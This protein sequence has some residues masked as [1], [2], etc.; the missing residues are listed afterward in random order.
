MSVLLE[1]AERF[2]SKTS[3]LENGCVVWTAYKTEEGYGLFSFNGET[4]RAHRM[5]WYLSYRS[6]PVHTL[7]HTCLNT[8]CVNVR[9]MQDI[10]LKRDLELM[11]ERGRGVNRR[12]GDPTKCVSGRHDW[13]E[14]N[15]MQWKNNRQC[16]VCFRERASIRRRNKKNK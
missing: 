10:T 14:K 5:S 3:V 15:I 11:W 16:R 1:L 13:V 7:D 8:S 2:L 6:W 4:I 9:H 12:R